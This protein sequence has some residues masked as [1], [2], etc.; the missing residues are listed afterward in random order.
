MPEQLSSVDLQLKMQQ[1]EI[2]NFMD[3]RKHCFIGQH[4]DKLFAQTL[5]HLFTFSPLMGNSRFGDNLMQKA[6]VFNWWN[7]WLIYLGS[8]I[9]LL[10]SAFYMDRFRGPIDDSCPFLRLSVGYCNELRTADDFFLKC[11]ALLIFD[12][13]YFTL[14]NFLYFPFH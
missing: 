12:H 10:F 5:N 14:C 13:F 3:E 6:W 7:L 8:E 9:W 1:D 2:W 11:Q 4:C